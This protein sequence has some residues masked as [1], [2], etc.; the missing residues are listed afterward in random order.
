M[1][2]LYSSPTKEQKEESHFEAFLDLVNGLHILEWE[3]TEQPDYLL[4]IDQKIVGLELTSLVLGGPKGKTSPAAIRNSQHECLVLASSLAEKRK[5]P[6]VNVKAKFIF[7][8]EPID[9][10]EAA[11]ELVEFVQS[12]V[13]EIDDTK[14]VNFPNV[15]LRFFKMVMIRLG[16]LNGER[17]LERH[18]FERIH[19]NWLLRD[20]ISEIQKRIDAKQKKL[21]GYLKKCEECWLL[22]GVDEW[23][24][25]EAV[26]ITD[27][28][29]GHAFR[30][31]FG[32]LFFLKNIE[33]NLME[34]RINPS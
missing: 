33:G 29:R 1:R 32:R 13:D 20:P 12:K 21:E 30:G 26:Y 10:E 31:E 22:I 14:P 7:D 2:T 28:T 9:V 8:D 34:L 11:N 23:T 4:Q 27:K 3:K 25:P 15:P 5:L 24:A 19:M 6:V 18:R 17:W 16:T